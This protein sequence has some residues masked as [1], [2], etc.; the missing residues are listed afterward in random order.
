MNQPDPPTQAASPTSGQ[1]APATPAA[2]GTPSPAGRAAPGAPTGGGPA[3]IPP[4]SRSAVTAA[5]DPAAEEPVWQGRPSWKQFYGQW[6]VWLIGS[7]VL[8]YLAS[9]IGQSGWPERWPT[10]WSLSLTIIGGIAAFLAVRQALMIYSVRYRLTTQRIFFDR[11]ILS[12]T[13]D[14]TELVRV[15]DVRIRRSIIDRLFGTGT[16]EITSTDTSDKKPI[17]TGIENPDRVSEEIR[18]HTRIVRARQTLFV[19]NV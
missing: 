1:P 4:P 18:R 6:L 19:E 5:T 11:G 10:K 9:Q 16:V 14:Q 17:L 7:V 15:D 13:T 2:A 8:L 12:L 3:I